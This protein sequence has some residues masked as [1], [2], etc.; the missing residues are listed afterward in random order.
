MEGVFTMNNNEFINAE[1]FFQGNCQKA[2]KMLAHPDKIDRMLKRLE[3]KLQGLPK[4][5][6]A[7][8]YIPKMG[9]LINSYIRGQYMD[10]P[11]GTIIGVIGVVMY[12]VLP[13]DAVPDFVP[14]VGYLDDAAVASGSLYLIK[15]DLDEYMRWRVLIGLD[16]D[17]SVDPEK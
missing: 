13:I 3:K 5:G 1:E 16:S 14:G 8:A 17:E 10:V 12:F 15:G 9:M 4:L 2:E 11:I 6:G 7:L